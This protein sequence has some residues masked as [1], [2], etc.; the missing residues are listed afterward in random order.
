MRVWGEDDENARPGSTSGVNMGC[1]VFS[2]R[3]SVFSYPPCANIIYGLN[4]GPTR[5]EILGSKF[6]REARAFAD[7]RRGEWDNPPWLFD[8]GGG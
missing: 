3:F 8:F 5:G 1:L 6:K 7:Q 2:D 4:R